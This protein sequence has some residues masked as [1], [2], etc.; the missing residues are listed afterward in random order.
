MTNNTASETSQPAKA[1]TPEE[2]YARRVAQ[3]NQ[4]AAVPD[5]PMPLIYGV[6]DEIYQRVTS[7]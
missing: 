2:R 5:R 1:E 6:I 3:Y 7:K 4:M